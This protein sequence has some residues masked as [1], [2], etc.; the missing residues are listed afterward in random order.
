MPRERGRPR[1]FDIDHALDRAV[2]IFWKHGYQDASLHELTEAMGLS[3][4]SLYAAFGD[5]EALYLKGLQRYLSLLI[6][7]HAGKLNDEPE[8]RKALDGFLR[9]LAAMLA[10]PALPGGCFIINGTADCGGSTIPASVEMALREAL[11][12]TETMVLERLVRAEK[13]G[14]LPAGMTPH[15]MA[16]LFGSLIAGL[17]VQAKSGADLAKLTMVIEAA[18]AVWPN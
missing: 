4:P 14:Q 17:G 2:E 10:D 11:Q 5:K 12:G 7:R 8:G 13:D 15:A 16:A 9:S 6:G 18:M 1:T 3:K